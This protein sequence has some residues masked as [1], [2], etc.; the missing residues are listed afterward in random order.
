MTLVRLVLSVCIVAMTSCSRDAAFAPVTSPAAPF[1]TLDGGPYLL[2]VV[3]FFDFK[4]GKSGYDP[5]GTPGGRRGLVGTAA[6][7]YGSAFAGGDSKCA[8]GN[9]KGCGVIYKLTPQMG[10]STYKETVLVTFTG[11]NGAVPYASVH[12][13]AGGDI[14]GTTYYGGQ[15]KGGTVFK[16]H[17]SGSG[18]TESIIHSFGNGSDGAHP[19]ARVLDMDGVL[20]GTTIGG[21]THKRDLCKTIGGSQDGSCGTVFSIDL[22]TGAERVLHSFGAADDGAS[23]YAG[24][25]YANGTFYGTTDLG[26]RNA[27]CGTVYN[28]SLT[29]QE[30]ILHSFANAPDGCK[31]LSA[32][33]WINGSLY[34]TTSRGGGNFGPAREGAVF[35]IDIATGVEQVL[36]KFGEGNDGSEPE[37][38]LLYSGGKLY[39]TTSLGGGTAGCTYGC[40]TIFRLDPSGSQYRRLYAFGGGANGAAPTDRVLFTDGSFFGTTSAGG[41]HGFGTGFK[42]TL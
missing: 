20:Y 18:Y 8:Y 5:L 34:G 14:F 17:P 4:G 10:K 28:I 35:S 16:L 25:I 3:P 13:V 31:P 15:Y 36:H 11:P 27:Y 40:G 12:M 1:A 42:L 29:G 41:L 39:G 6:A 19:Y 37:G 24:L 22:T 9:G 21:G 38:A 23:P 33:A 30:R 2:H 26:G 7:L 32:L